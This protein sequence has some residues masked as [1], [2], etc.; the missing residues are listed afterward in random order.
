[1]LRLYSSQLKH[2]LFQEIMSWSNLIN[3]TFHCIL[4]ATVNEMN[5]LVAFGIGSRHTFINESKTPNYSREFRIISQVLSN[6]QTCFKS[7]SSI[8]LV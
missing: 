7:N 6:N 2:F 4:L 3:A 5:Y 8:D 1:M